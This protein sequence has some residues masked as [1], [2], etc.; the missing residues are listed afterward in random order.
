MEKE[1][2]EKYFGKG[3]ELAYQL[4]EMFLHNADLYSKQNRL[5]MHVTEVKTKYNTLVLK[6]RELTEP[7][8]KPFWQRIFKRDKS[9]GNV[10]QPQPQ[11]Q[12][13]QSPRENTSSYSD[14]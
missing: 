7:Q 11:P 1:T 14:V 3:N 9:I 8:Q 2:E 6:H 5:L 13:P 4:F 12:R 10:N